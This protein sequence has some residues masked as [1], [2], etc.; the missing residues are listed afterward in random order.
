MRIREGKKK[1]ESHGKQDFSTLDENDVKIARL[2]NN[3]FCNELEPTLV[4][5]PIHRE[6]KKKTNLNKNSI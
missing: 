5:R 3:Y 6:P 1:T 4:P 2:V